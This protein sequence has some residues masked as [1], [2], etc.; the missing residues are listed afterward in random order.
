MKLQAAIDR[1]T[2]PAAMELIRQI[3]SHAD[4]VEIGTSLIK[5]YGLAGSVGALAREFPQQA[6]LADIKTCDEGAYEFQKTFEAG[7]AI[8]TVMGF[9]SVAT[10]RACEEVARSF[11]RSYL[12]DLLECDAAR[13]RLLAE[14]FPTAIFCIHLPSD[15]AG[16]GLGAL[17]E[18]MAGQLTASTSAPRIAAAGGVQ[19]ATIPLLQQLGIEIGIVGSAITKAADIS[20]A[21]RAFYEAMHGA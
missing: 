15:C 3:G 12:I 11:G 1:V 13:V 19:L 4:L 7:A 6:F 9:S 14:E 20:A 2:I 18:E 16:E 5:D 21:A 17:I 10:I 8:A